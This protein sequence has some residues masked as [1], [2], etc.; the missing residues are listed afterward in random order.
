MNDILILAGVSLLSAGAGWLV[1]S[2]HY[3]SVD[4]ARKDALIQAHSLQVRINRALDLV[5]P[6]SRNGNGT[7]QKIGKILRGER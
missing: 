5:P 4:Q 6:Y 7:V 2:I 3:A 1:T